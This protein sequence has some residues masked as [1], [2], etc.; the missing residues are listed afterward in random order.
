MVEGEQSY[1]SLLKKSLALG[2][3]V[4]KISQPNEAVAVLMPNITNTLALILG[5]SAFNRIPALLNY[6][7]GST[8]LQNA[9][10]CGNIKTVITSKKFIETA[11]LESVVANLK[12]L[13]IIYLEDLRTQFTLLDKAWL[14]AFALH[15][16]RAAIKNQRARRHCSH[17]IY[18]RFRRKNPKAWCIRTKVFWPILPK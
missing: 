12:N 9:C 4:T 13:N 14:M 10:A 6:T 1:K 18:L 5:I 3:L 16:P 2:R 15:F 7:S 17:F 8:G 11:K